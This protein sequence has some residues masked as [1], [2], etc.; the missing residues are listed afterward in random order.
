MAMTAGTATA[1]GGVAAQVEISGNCDNPSFPLCA[2]APDGVGLGGV[3]S[4]AGLDT[5]TGSGTFADPSSM[6]ATATF[7]GHVLG[8]GGPRGSNGPSSGS[9]D[10]FGVWYLEPSLG[11]ALADAGPA[12]F[13]FYN[14]ANYSGAVYVLDYFPGSGENDFIAVVPAQQGHYSIHPAAGVSIQTQIAP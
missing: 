12:A 11:Q 9:R 5:S 7:C 10:P 13:P 8:G 4:W 2:P 6:D 1:A 3:W 14:P